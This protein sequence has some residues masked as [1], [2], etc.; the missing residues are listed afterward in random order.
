MTQPS[1]LLCCPLI[2]PTGNLA[3]VFGS[4]KECQR[5]LQLLQRTRQ[6]L[7]TSLDEK[8]QKLLRVDAPKPTKG[9][10]GAKANCTV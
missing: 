9:T 8:I 2:V 7:R 6:N 10:N 4:V 5:V 3:L 1:L